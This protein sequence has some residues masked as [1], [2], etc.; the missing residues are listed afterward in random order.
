MTDRMTTAS[1]LHMLIARRTTVD[2][3]VVDRWHDQ[4]EDFSH[5]CT[6][7]TGNDARAL[8]PSA[9]EVL[10]GAGNHRALSDV[11]ATGSHLEGPTSYLSRYLRKTRKTTGTAE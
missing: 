11:H 6:S 9:A 7:W 5:S 10:N 4:I 3:D 8:D 2:A 1:D